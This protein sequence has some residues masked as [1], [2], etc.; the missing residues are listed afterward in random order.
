MDTHN[1]HRVTE[2]TPA[3]GNTALS[4]ALYQIENNLFR[5]E[6]QRLKQSTQKV[7]TDVSC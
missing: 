3:A 2:A 7:K 4:A 6:Q 1:D 5:Q